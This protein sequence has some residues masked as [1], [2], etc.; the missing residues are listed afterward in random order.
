MPCDNNGNDLPLHWPP[1][2]SSQAT[3]NTPKWYPFTSCL[4]FNFTWHHFV[5]MESS[6]WTI[7]K[8][9]DLWVASVIQ[10]GGSTAWKSADKLYATIDR[11]QHGDAPWMTHKF[12]YQG[13]LPPSPPK[14]MTQTYKLS[15]HDTCWVLHQQFANPGFKDQINYTPYKQFNKAR[16]H[17]WSN[18]MSGDWA[19]KWVVSLHQTPCV[20]YM[21]TDISSRILLQLIL[22]PMALYSYLSYQAAIKQLF[23]LQPDTRNITWYISP[24]AVLPILNAGHMG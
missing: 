12:H 16:K 19:W 3:D 4:K 21:F 14:W 11:I 8:G 20:K 13:P 22:L 10:H 24:Q 1:P 2:N 5:E 17:I 7:N 23:L 15:V 6:E 18:F 9:L